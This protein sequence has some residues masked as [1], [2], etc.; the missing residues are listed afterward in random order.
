MFP[1]IV[2]ET[3]DDEGHTGGVIGEIILKIS[4]RKTFIDSQ[5]LN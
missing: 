2:P 1:F 4:L 3:G 5:K